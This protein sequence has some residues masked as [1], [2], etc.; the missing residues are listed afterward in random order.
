MNCKFLLKIL[1][2]LLLVAN[3]RYNSNH[4]FGLPMRVR[5]HCNQCNS[6][7]SLELM[8]PIK[9]HLMSSKWIYTTMLLFNFCKRVQISCN[10]NHTS[11][12]L[13]FLALNQ[14]VRIKIL[15]KLVDRVYARTSKKLLIPAFFSKKT[16]IKLFRAKI[17]KNK[18]LIIFHK[19][20]NL[21]LSVHSLIS[22]SM[23]KK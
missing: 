22:N 23:T 19:Y 20:K 11:A 16:R 4:Q 5:R 14:E 18:K 15:L 8:S 6:Q 10:N 3:H 7:W 12:K 21:P 1:L 13:K 17:I 9:T 2:E